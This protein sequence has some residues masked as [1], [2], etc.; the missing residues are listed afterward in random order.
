MSKMK[1]KIGITAIGLVFTLAA[2]S[3]P[4]VDNAGDPTS[5]S[6]FLTRLID[7]L[8]GPQVQVNVTGLTGILTFNVNGESRTMNASGSAAFEMAIGI[9]YSFAITRQP[10]GGLCVADRSRGDTGRASFSA[11]V[12]ISCRTVHYVGGDFAQ[13]NGTARAGLARLN[14]DGSLDTTFDIGTGFTGGSAAVYAIAQ[15]YDG[16]GDIYVGGD[17]TAYN[18]VS[19]TNLVRLNSDGTLDNDFAVG[20]GATGGQVNVILPMLDGSGR[21]YIGGNFTTY[22]SSALT[23]IVRANPDG[24]VDNSFVTGAGF[25][26]QVREIADARDGSGKLYVGGDFA[27]YAGTG[28]TRLARLNSDGTLDTTFTVGGGPDGD[29]RT[30]APALDTSGDIYIGGSFTSYDGNAVNRI[31]RVNSD[32]T[33]DTG[34][35]TDGCVG[36]SHR[37]LALEDG[38]NDIYLGTSAT[39]CRQGTAVGRTARFNPNSTIDT[40]FDTSL[41]FDNTVFGMRFHPAGD[42]SLLM[43]G[44]FTTYKSSPHVGVARV[45][46]NGTADATFNA[47]TG[48]TGGGAT[49]YTI[50][51]GWYT[52]PANPVA[53]IQKGIYFFEGNPD[54][55]GN[56]GG[57][58][59]ADAACA[60]AAASQ[61]EPIKSCT[62]TRA[63]ASFSASDSIANMPTTYGFSAVEPVYGP[64]G[65][66][67]AYNWNSI[68]NPGSVNYIRSFS[69]AGTVTTN[70]LV[71]TFSDNTGNFD[72]TNNCTN[73]TSN[74]GDSGATGQS[75][76]TGTTALLLL[77]RTCSLTDQRL[78]C[79]C[80]VE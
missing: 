44:T 43:V 32:G 20:G 63:F 33:Y 24:S 45:S 26:G 5:E 68:A 51:R 35:V 34:Y 46:A 10:N 31:A 71:W 6:Y 80:A 14:V 37:I 52:Q 18:G 39:M 4:S 54:T 58:S 53:T 21:V 59:G 66:G 75:T 56:I 69:T 3:A 60:T 28:R 74:G 42:G 49:V 40:S 1:G 36:I 13:F 77:T 19:V 65:I 64:T 67:I 55:M 29:V 47:G 70:G 23:R 79:V 73:G 25:D 12:N 78:L 72:A 2:C 50:D 17:F 76:S 22:N 61:P 41:G 57:R 62:G 15:A 16:S 7:A 9:P 27:N 8:L 30:I 48:A 11:T 38:G